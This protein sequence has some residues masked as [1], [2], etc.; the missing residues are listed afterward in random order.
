MQLT[1]VSHH[2]CPY[3]QRAAI[4]LLEK[5]VPF[6]RRWVDL[7]NK[8]DWFRAISPLGKTPVLLADDTPV[9]ESAVI[10]E[11]LDETHEPRLH[12]ADPL[13]R[14]QHRAWMEFGS[15]VLNTIWAFY[16]A[17]DAAA[18][19]ARR[20]ELRTKFEQLEAVVEGPFFAGERFSIVDAVFGPVFRYFD[21]FEALGEPSLFGG[22]PRVRAWRAALA[23]RPAVREAA[24]PDYRER[25][26]QFLLD[27]RSELSRRI[28]R[29][30][31]SV[32]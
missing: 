28:E 12:P 26:T 9:F 18:L 14:A 32:K 10:C 13:Q 2:L 3:V 20:D 22:L 1:L 5:G 23:Q 15:A 7:A 25:L 11:Y 21:V 27:R 31:A 19:E 29:Q 4:V 8:P 17:P 16:T 24:V 30:L 6:G